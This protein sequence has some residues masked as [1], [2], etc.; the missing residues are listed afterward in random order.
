[1]SNFIDNAA[2]ERTTPGFT[3][4]RSATTDSNCS[5]HSDLGYFQK[6]A[7]F[8]DAMQP[9]PCFLNIDVDSGW[10]AEM[11]GLK[12]TLNQECFIKESIKQ[13]LQ[14]VK[15][16]FVD[17]K[18]VKVDTLTASIHFNMGVIGKFLSLSEEEQSKR[19]DMKEFCEPWKSWIRP[20]GEK[21]NIIL[22]ECIKDMYYKDNIIMYP[23]GTVIGSIASH[24]FP[25]V[26][27]SYAYRELLDPDGY[28]APHDVLDFVNEKLHEAY[29]QFNLWCVAYDLDKLSIFD[30]DKQPD[31]RVYGIF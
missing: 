21:R 31:M 28:G 19:P 15:E 3:P 8:C 5:T 23:K 18:D 12:L 17:I 6:L 7:R 13:I 30:L 4:Q 29:P 11:S 20:L 22:T 1:M 25:K 2:D 10:R 27:E 9:E 24:P 26:S 14:F 16:G